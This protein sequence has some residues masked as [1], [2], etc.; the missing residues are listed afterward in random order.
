MQHSKR[1]RKLR[2]R[3]K[4]QNTLRSKIFHDHPN[5]TKQKKPKTACR[6]MIGNGFTTLK[7]A[8]I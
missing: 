4:T 3:R 5:K 2:G 8:Q 1:S 6:S 7:K